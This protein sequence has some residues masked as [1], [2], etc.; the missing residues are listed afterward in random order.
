METQGL[1]SGMLG[2]VEL[3]PCERDSFAHMPDPKEQFRDLYL[4]RL[5]GY[6]VDKKW[7]TFLKSE[8]EVL[9]EKPAL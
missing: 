1:R 4:N 8:S 6:T 3:G 9:R 2:S 5:F 7:V